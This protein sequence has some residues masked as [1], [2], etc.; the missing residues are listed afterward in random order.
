MYNKK[1]YLLLAEKIVVLRGSSS[2]NISMQME[3]GRHDSCRDN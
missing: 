2:E 3:S 1:Y